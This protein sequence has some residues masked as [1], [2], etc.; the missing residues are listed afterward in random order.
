MSQAVHIKNGYNYSG[1][2]FITASTLPI[3][4]M[5]T[6][7]TQGSTKPVTSDGIYQVTKPFVGAQ[8]SIAGIGGTVPAPQVGDED[9][10]LKSDGT[11]S[12]LSTADAPMPLNPSASQIEDF[13]DGAIWIVTE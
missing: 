11:W 7:P 9:K 3:G 13:P 10:F 8:G 12:S 1:Y 2:N 5:D 6:T 4:S